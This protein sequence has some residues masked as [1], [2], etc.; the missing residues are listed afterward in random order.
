M[1]RGS[2]YNTIDPKGRI[3]IP[4]RFREEIS[5]NGDGLVV[6]RLDGSLVVYP[7]NTW[8]EIENKI[9][10]LAEKSAQMRRFR[11]IFVGSA[12]ELTCDKQ[13]RILIPPTLRQHAEL[14][15][16]IVL[17]GSLKHFEI[18]SRER[19]ERENERFLEDM[20]KEEFGSEIAKLGL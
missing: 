19:W 2:S 5:Q 17:V 12:V 9:I 16:E 4:T 18:W 8:L 20:K 3:I 15:K 14:E 1:F 13:G 6:T 7:Y 10:A 11:R